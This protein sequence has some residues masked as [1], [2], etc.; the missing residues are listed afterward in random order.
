MSNRLRTPVTRCRPI[1]GLAT[2]LLLTLAACGADVEPYTPTLSGIVNEGG[3]GS[4]DVS[5]SQ[6][7]YVERAADDACADREIVASGNL[8]GFVDVLNQYRE[9][10]VEVFAIDVNCGSFSLGVWAPGE[11]KGAGVRIGTVLRMVDQAS[12]T[13]LHAWLVPNFP[14][15][16]RDRIVMRESP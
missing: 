10:S 13:T 2:A 3:E 1:F 6:G 4:G 14:P 5:F 9:R 16:G 11:T 7:T 15:I 12:G 8:S